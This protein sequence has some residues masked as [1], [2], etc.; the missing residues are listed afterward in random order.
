MVDI[1]I[2]LADENLPHDI[3]VTLQREGIDIHS[4]AQISPG[5]EDEEVLSLA[6]K[7]KRTL[8]TFDKDFGEIIFK[9]RKQSYGVVLLRVHPQT[10]EYIL[11]VLRKVLAMNISF[12]HSFCVVESYRIRVIS[13]Q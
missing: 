3:I 4:V 7:Q 11:S 2:F 9:A 8:I 12:Q 13:L 5:A 1:L 6:Y 10:E